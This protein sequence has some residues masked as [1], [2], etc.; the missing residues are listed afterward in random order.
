MELYT[1]FFYSLGIDPM[2][3]ASLGTTKIRRRT[4]YL[5]ECSRYEHKHSICTGE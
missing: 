2:E 5:L 3:L 4:T 1:E